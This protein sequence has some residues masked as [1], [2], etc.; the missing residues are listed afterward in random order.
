MKK[1]IDRED[2]INLLI[3]SLETYFDE[4]NEKVNLSEGENTKL[5]GGDGVLNSLGLVSY[6][7]EIEE[8]L[9]DEYDV[10]VTLADE[11]AMSRRTS[12]FGRITYLADY[13]IEVLNDNKND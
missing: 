8:L 6:I 12:P 11:K 3:S 9:E 1:N 13:I 5:F 2:I 7:V 10:S 4:I